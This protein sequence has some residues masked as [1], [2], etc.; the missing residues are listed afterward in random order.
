[1]YIH[2]KGKNETSKGQRPE[3]PNKMQKI[4]RQNCRI[5]YRIAKA[6]F[7]NISKKKFHSFQRYKNAQKSWSQSILRKDNIH[8]YTKG[9]THPSI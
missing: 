9:L 6:H 5:A 4:Q 8:F 1:M 2:Q 7:G 3:R